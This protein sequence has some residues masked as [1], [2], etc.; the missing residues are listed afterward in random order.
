MKGVM[1]GITVSVLTVVLCVAAVAD[2]KND[3]RKLAG[4]SERLAEKTEQLRNE[5]ELQ[6]EINA[7]LEER[8]VLLD[9]HVE[10]F[11]KGGWK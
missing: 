7:E 11:I 2:A 10:F 9:S 1:T 8:I 3:C 4:E 6:K 5:I